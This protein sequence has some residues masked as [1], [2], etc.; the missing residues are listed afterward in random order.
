[1]LLSEVVCNNIRYLSFICYS[2]DLI[3]CIKGQLLQQLEHFTEISS[4]PG[5][6]IYGINRK[7]AS[8][9]TGHTVHISNFVVVSSWIHLLSIRLLDLYHFIHNS[10]LNVDKL[11]SSQQE[12]KRSD[13]LRI[14]QAV[15]RTEQD[16]WYNLK[17][18]YWYH[19][20]SHWLITIHHSIN[21]FISPNKFIVAVGMDFSQLKFK[22]PRLE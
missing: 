14:R 22:C 19:L 18:M 20:I 11:W 6:Q 17:I 3:V 21:I 5:G 12:L 8:Y 4:G 2:G 16:D 9:M 7:S 15:S 10:S 13:W 1:M